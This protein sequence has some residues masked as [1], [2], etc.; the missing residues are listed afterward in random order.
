[1]AFNPFSGSS[2]L[3]MA[4]DVA[5]TA[6]S[7]LVTATGS[8][9]EVIISEAA[10][11]EF[12]QSSNSVSFTGFNNPA[13]SATKV[14]HSR[15]LAGGTGS[16]TVRVRG[17]FSGDSNT[18]S[19]FTRFKRGTFLSFHLYLEKGT[20]YGWKALIGKVIDQ[21]IQVDGKLGALSLIGL[22]LGPRRE[23]LQTQYLSKPGENTA[24]EQ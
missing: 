20:T 7:D 16:W 1:M 13:D 5:L 10:S 21:N 11:F 9:V 3:F 14:I 19:T 22:G 18:V 2:A 15:E 6:G 24:V 12:N 17:S 8:E 4:I 23:P